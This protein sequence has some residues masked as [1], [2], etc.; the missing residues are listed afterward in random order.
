M[1]NDRAR[2]PGRPGPEA[3]PGAGA[4]GPLAIID[5]LSIMAFTDRGEQ[6]AKRIAALVRRQNI[7]ARVDVNR[8]TDLKK[9]ALAAFKTGN[10]LLF[11]GAVAIAVR[12]IAPLLKSKTS[13]PAVLVVDELGRFVIPILSGHIGGANSDAKA[14]AEA[15]GATPVITTATDIN[16]VFSIDT[17]ATENGYVI[18]NPDAIKLVSTALLEG[19]TVGLCSDFE[20]VG[21]LPPQ[22][23]PSLDGN[24]GI[25]ISLNT[26]KT[27]FKQTLKLVPKCFHVGVGTRKGIDPSLLLD[28]FDETLRNLSIPIEAV[29]TVSSIDIKKNEEAI[30]A[31]TQRHRVS[32]VTYRVDELAEVADQFS[33]S[34]FVKETVGVGNVCEAA[35]YLSAK[36]GMIELPKIAKDGATLAIARE[37]WRVSFETDYDRA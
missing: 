14:L 3:A 30:L 1:E 32:F 19:G 12:A 22:I 20:I 23:E 18:V 7:H 2:Q 13:D 34:A 10:T 15:I 5:R 17:F 25:C 28:L 29:A 11:V 36:R 8:V 21:Q 24:I 4:E 33:Q 37:A 26:Q 35:A 6:L 27:P 9:S 31:V 16:G